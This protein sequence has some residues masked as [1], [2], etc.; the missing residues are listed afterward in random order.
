MQK[1]EK[2]RKNLCIWRYITLCALRVYSSS[3]HHISF[4]R[5]WQIHRRK[6]IY[7][8]LVDF[9]VNFL[10]TTSSGKLLEGT[11][12]IRTQT[13]LSSYIHATWFASLNDEMNNIFGYRRWSRWCEG[14]FYLSP[15]C[16]PTGEAKVSPSLSPLP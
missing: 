8:G 1:N 7:L 11:E 13:E 6:Q 10:S 16:S 12:E 15:K 2:R 5:R 14:S 3:I 9:L 4:Y